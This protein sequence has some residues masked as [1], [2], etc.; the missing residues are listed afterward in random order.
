MSGYP[1]ER[2]REIDRATP[3]QVQYILPQGSERV[4]LV[5]CIGQAVIVNGDVVNMSNR[6]ITIG[7]PEA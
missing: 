3:D 1:K 7:V 5:S 2:R 6:L 4:T